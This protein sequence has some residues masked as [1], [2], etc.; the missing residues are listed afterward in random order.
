MQGMLPLPIVPQALKQLLQDGGF[1]S[2]LGF[3][4][5]FTNGASPADWSLGLSQQGLSFSTQG[6]GLAPNQVKHFCCIP[7]GDCC[8][9]E[10]AGTS[11]RRSG[12]GS[13]QLSLP[14]LEGCKV[15][16]LI[17]VTPSR[18]AS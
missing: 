6:L 16:D 15:R 4:E 13:L 3:Y 18:R 9:S 10:L 2:M 12:L 14:L 8:E 17:V 1:P 5:A 7:A 11:G